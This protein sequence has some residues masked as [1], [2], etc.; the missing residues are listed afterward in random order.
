MSFFLSNEDIQKLRESA[1]RF[2]SL[3]RNIVAGK[4]ISKYLSL[5]AKHKKHNEWINHCIRCAINSHACPWRLSIKG[6]PS[7]TSFNCGIPEWNLWKNRSEFYKI[8][9]RILWCSCGSP[10]ETCTYISI[11]EKM[12]RS[13]PCISFQCSRCLFTDERDDPYFYETYQNPVTCVYEDFIKINSNRACLNYCYEGI[14]WLS[15]WDKVSKL[16]YGGI[17]STIF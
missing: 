2:H 5:F 9:G 10:V 3:F 4:K 11:G 6:L 12:S 15:T 8:P 7:F 13:T 14:Y 1:R 17:T 16:Y